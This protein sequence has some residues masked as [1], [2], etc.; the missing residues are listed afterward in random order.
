MQNGEPGRV[1][2]H[3]SP[4]EITTALDCNDSIQHRYI[5]GSAQF[6]VV[7]SSSSLSIVLSSVQHDQHPCITFSVRYGRG[8]R[9]TWSLLALLYVFDLT[10]FVERKKTD[11]LTVDNKPL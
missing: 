8:S 11:C 3:H 2:R 4:A 5:A 10:A 6:A 9:Q 1:T 7:S